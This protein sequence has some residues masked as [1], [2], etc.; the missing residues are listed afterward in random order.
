MSRILSEASAE[1][2][3]EVPFGWEMHPELIPPP[4]AAQ[5]LSVRD[6]KAKKSRWKKAWFWIR[7]GG[8]KRMQHEI[9]FRH[10]EKWS[11]DG[12]DASPRKAV[13]IAPLSRGGGWR[14]SKIRRNLEGSLLR[15]RTK[16]LVFARTKWKS[17]A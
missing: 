2:Y 16:L 5:S 8:G 14:V 17:L 9:S 10:N 12:A 6:D 13:S 3:G 4:A 11:V 15:S 1:E 7:R